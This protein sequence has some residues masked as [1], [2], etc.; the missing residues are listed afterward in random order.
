MTNLR[1]DISIKFAGDS[2]D[3]MQLTGSQFTSNTALHG[4]DFTT[5][6]NYPAEIR[7]PQGT[8][9]GVSGFQIHFGSTEINTPGDEFDV[10]V[11]MNA[12][13]LKDSLSGLKKGGII[14]ADPAGFD[15][16]NLRLAGYNPDEDLLQNPSIHDYDLIKVEATRLT[17]E[18]LSES[19][20]DPKAKDR[21]KNMFVL[22]LLLWMYSRSLDSVDSFIAAKFKQDEDLKEANTKVLRT[23]FYYGETAELAKFK[24]EV[25]P[26][27]LAAGEYR[28]IMGNKATAL[29]LMAAAAK[30]K[31]PLFYGSYPITPASDVL[32]EL[33][34]Y[35]GKGVQSYQAEDE[36][37]AV[38]AAIGASFGGALGV[39]GTSGPGLA[40]KSEAINLALMLELPLVVVNVQRA[41]PSTGMPTKTEQSDLLFAMFGRNGESPIPIVAAHSPSN[42]FEAAYW[43][44]KIAVEK[45]TPV[46]F[47]SDGYLANGSEPW[48]FPK[49]ADMPGITPNF[50]TK[51]ELE[52]EDFQAYKRNED[53]VRKWVAPGTP[54]KQHRI[55]GLEKEWNTGNVSYDPAN[56]QKMTEVRAKKIENLS[57][58]VPQQV[59]QVGEKSGDLLI[60]GWGNTSGAIRSAVKKLINEGY[61]VSQVQIGFIHPFPE[62]LS[63]ILDGFKNVLV[64]EL[65][66]GQLIK[67]L[68]M[69]FPKVRFSAIN[70][71]QGIPFK[72]SEIFE[73]ATH[74]LKGGSDA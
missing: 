58:Y 28:N 38:C 7:A 57:T 1:E 20:L 63:A 73:R 32:H 55:G 30:L 29:G 72:T 59:I 43:A 51:E 40:L 24:T 39:T 18:A 19:S 48:R 67:L 4:N 8:I 41:G 65:N 52:K 33:A 2:G 17:Q 13:A 9:H 14:I 47:L 60:V 16:K 69:N 44:C 27:K 3:G 70:K 23:G 37:A 68:K 50:L 26:A 61:A 74:I 36:I 53:L 10:L 45:M 49:L 35:L 54:G 12:A 34:K 11:A 5:F 64:P 22:G 62:N 66:N 21:S 46:I 42:C 6:P 25:R 15:S 31:L 71:I 56:H